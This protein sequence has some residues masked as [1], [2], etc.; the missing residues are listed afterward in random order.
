MGES[1]HDAIYV[2]M[3]L[4]GMTIYPCEDAG[5]WAVA[6][7]DASLIRTGQSARGMK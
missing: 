1:P 5:S 7:F 4:C 3:T 2:L 6:G